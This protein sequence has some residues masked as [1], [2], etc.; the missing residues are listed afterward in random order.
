MPGKIR[1]IHGYRFHS[2]AFRFPLETQDAIDHQKREAMRQN[3]HH[4]I[5]IETAFSRRKRPGN[6]KRRDLG[7]LFHDRPRQLRVS[8]MT[9]LYRNDMT[10]NASADE[11]D[12]ADDVEDFVASEVTGKMP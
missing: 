7:V 9:R 10:P 4:L 3:F 1:F 6:G 8:G 12:V 2:G 5:N 11:R